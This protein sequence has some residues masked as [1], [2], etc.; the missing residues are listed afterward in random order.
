MKFEGLIF[1]SAPLNAW[2]VLFCRLLWNTI[3]SYPIQKSLILRG[4]DMDEE[5]K[6]PK[7]WFQENEIPSIL[8][9]KCIFYGEQEK[10]YAQRLFPW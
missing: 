2:R 4:W 10:N 5:W 9:L 8:N 7:W 6:V 3:L 1:F